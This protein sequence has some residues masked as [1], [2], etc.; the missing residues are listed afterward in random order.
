MTVLLL[1]AATPALRLADKPPSDGH[2]RLRNLDGLRGI[3][4]LAVVFHHGAVYHRYLIDSVWDPWP[5][6]FYGI[7]G[8]VGVSLFFMITGFLFWSRL[9]RHQGKSNWSRLYI[10][11]V[12]RIGPLYLAAVAAMLVSVA[13][14]GGSTLHTSIGGFV[15]DLAPWL[16]L[17]LLDGPDIAGFKDTYLVLAGVIW[18][19][20]SEWFFYI[21]LPVSALLARSRRLHLPAVALMLS[22][23]LL[24]LAMHPAPSGKLRLI[25]LFL[26]G[27][28]CASLQAEGW[29]KSLPDKWS[30]AALILLLGLVVTTQVGFTASCI[31]LLGMCF[32]LIVSGTT[33]FGLLVTRAAVRLGDISYGIYM[34]QGLALAALLRPEPLRTIATTLPIGHWTLVLLSIILLIAVATMSHAVIE[35]P[36]IALGRRFAA[37][38]AGRLQYPST[39][40][41]SPLPAQRRHARGHAS[42]VVEARATIDT[43]GEVSR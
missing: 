1:L 34:L 37:S 26:T 29:V 40:E 8:P 30:S 22:A 7:L 17:G 2:N 13:I 12:F 42:R 5:S 25:A 20:K 16:A 31:L 19:L 11:R 28:I 3:L 39:V 14:E 18:T 9:I 35:R 23:S 10:D 27:M 32:F 24:R 38:L 6:Q 36:G 33:V 15:R 21:S 43:A 41:D 4:A